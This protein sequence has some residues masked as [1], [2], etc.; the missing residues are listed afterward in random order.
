[1]RSSL[2]IPCTTFS[3]ETSFLN[4]PFLWFSSAPLGK[5]WNNTS[6]DATTTYFHIPPKSLF[7][8]ILSRDIISATQTV[9]QIINKLNQIDINIEFKE[10]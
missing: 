1:V 6:N 7:S 10:I 9:K 8:M 4:V 5:Y 2:K 3:P